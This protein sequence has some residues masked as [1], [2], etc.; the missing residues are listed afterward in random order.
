[1][2]Q[3]PDFLDEARKPVRLDTVLRLL[4]RHAHFEQYAQFL[5][6]SQF[7]PGAVQALR[8]AEI[9]HRI[10][11]SKCFRR[12]G[13]LVALQVS[14]K[15]P[16]PRNLRPSAELSF[17]LLHAILAKMPRPRFIRGA[18]GFRRVRLRHRD[19][20]DFFRAASC[21]PR[22]RRDA[23]LY[24]SEIL[25]NVIPIHRR[26]AAP[27]TRTKI[28]TRVSLQC[29][30]SPV[31]LACDPCPLA[32]NSS[33]SKASTAAASA[34]RSTCSPSLSRCAAIPFTPPVSR[35]TT[36]GSGAWSAASSM[37][38]SARSKASI[39]TSLPCSTPGIASKPSLSSK[40][41]W[42]RAK[43]CSPTVTLLRISRIK[44]LAPR[45]TA[46]PNSF[47]GSN[48][49]STTSTASRARLSS[50]IFGCRRCAR[51]L[52]CN[53]N[54]RAPT[55]PRNK[56]C[57]KPVCA[58]SKTPPKCTMNSPGAPPGPLSDASTAPRTPCA[59]PTKSPPRFLPLS[60]RSCYRRLL[61]EN[62]RYELL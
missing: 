2:R 23:L 35:N 6:R 13:G 61:P 53:K 57:R 52:S 49:S 46:A 26:P 33:P 21:P 58:I 56:I 22:R 31:I 18:N 59:S 43:S 25:S 15:V 60:S 9:V 5:S 3:S 37:A 11:A 16:P 12:A 41:R 27:R 55:L 17:P 19:Q 38:N 24:Y 42:R 54:P 44:P 62:S 50:C 28:L 1:M 34:R 40:P 29:R 10:H 48:I 32:E 8:Q 51:K 45:P 4:L 7:R 47:P 39:R 20:G 14:H 30:A 36:R